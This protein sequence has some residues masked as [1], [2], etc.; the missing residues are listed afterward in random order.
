MF[1]S[2][3]SEVS[4]IIL[5]ETELNRML[6][7]N[8]LPLIPYA[9]SGRHAAALIA[10]HELE[11]GWYQNTVTATLRAGEF[12]LSSTGVALCR[13]DRKSA[14]Y[15]AVAKVVMSALHVIEK[16]NAR[17]KFSPSDARPQ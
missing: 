9:R 15:L 12:A 10:E 16:E 2:R 1:P 8:L 13:E 11:I 4:D 7:P 5:V 6:R 17:G 14:L 3:E